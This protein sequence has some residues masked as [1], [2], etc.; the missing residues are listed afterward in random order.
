MT[1]EQLSVYQR[2]YLQACLLELQAIKPGNVG[3]HADGHGMRVQQFET[4]ARV[5]AD[6]LF[7]PCSCVGERVYKAVK[8]TQEAVSDN[9]NLG[10]ILLAAPLVEALIMSPNYQ[11]LQHNL[12][13]PTLA[14]FFFGFW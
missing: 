6:A 10:I 2:C 8:A 5:S 4:S 11:G 13:S 1:I 12:R 7:K 3:F 14:R 9:T